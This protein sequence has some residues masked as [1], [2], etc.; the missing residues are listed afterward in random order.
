MQKT[1]SIFHLPL[2][3]CFSSQLPKKTGGKISGRFPVSSCG[4]GHPHIDFVIST[5]QSTFSHGKTKIKYTMTSCRNIEEWPKGF[6]RIMEKQ[7]EVYQNDFCLKIYWY[8]IEN[9]S[10]TQTLCRKSYFVYLSLVFLGAGGCWKPES[11][12]LAVLIASV[13]QWGRKH[14]FGMAQNWCA[15]GPEICYLSFWSC[16]LGESSNNFE[17]CHFTWCFSGSSGHVPC[18]VSFF[19]CECK[20]SRFNLASEVL[21][22]GLRL[23]FRRV[24]IVWPHLFHSFLSWKH[25]KRGHGFPEP[26]EQPWYPCQPFAMV[27]ITVIK[28]IF[29]NRWCF[30]VQNLCLFTCFFACFSP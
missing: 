28:L 30:L 19:F 22:T 26:T 5:Y 29:G 15:V 23:M 10:C 20:R 8:A 11:A 3:F 1:P 27:G 9:T 4:G 25:P 21:K 18:F 24:W 2:L 13:V 17:P 7:D 16:Y 14:P 12:K 6:L